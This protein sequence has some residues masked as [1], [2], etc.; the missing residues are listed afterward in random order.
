MDQLL[1][2]DRFQSFGSQ[3]QSGQSN[4]IGDP[5]LASVDKLGLHKADVVDGG[6]VM[7]KGMKELIADD[8]RLNTPAVLSTA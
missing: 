6:V 7:L 1:R 8:W 5:Q 3:C 2:P 4:P